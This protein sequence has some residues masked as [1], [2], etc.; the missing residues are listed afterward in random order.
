MNC[1]MRTCEDACSGHGVCLDGMCGCMKGY[2]GKQC[3]KRQLSQ[4]SVKRAFNGPEIDFV[5]PDEGYLVAAVG[6]DLTTVVNSEP[7][8]D[9]STIGSG[10]SL[11]ADE[12][13]EIISGKK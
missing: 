12:I 5:N 2:G 7:K 9:L 4:T 13:Q 3:E 10:L 1:S 11:S 8:L 6:N